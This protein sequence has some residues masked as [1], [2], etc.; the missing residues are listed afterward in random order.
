MV[1]PAVPTTAL[2]IDPSMES[3][4]EALTLRKVVPSEEVATNASNT[5]KVWG[6]P[7][8]IET[9]L[10]IDGYIQPITL[11]EL[12]VMKPTTMWQHGDARGWFRFSYKI[13]TITYQVRPAESIVDANGVVWH[14]EGVDDYRWNFIGY[15]EA[16]LRRHAPDKVVMV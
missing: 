13:N 6:E 1:N 12:V 2:S 8:Y 4:F 16:H 14:V 11:N 3:L 5:D 9:D 10:I 15:R 7:T